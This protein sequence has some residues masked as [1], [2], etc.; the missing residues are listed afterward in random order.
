MGA[1]EAARPP[2]S[3]SYHS[4]VPS[5]VGPWPCPGEVAVA[6]GGSPVQTHEGTAAWA[7]GLADDLEKQQGTSEGESRSLPAPPGRTHRGP[8][9]GPA[10]CRPWLAGFP[11][12]VTNICSSWKTQQID[13]SPKKARLLWGLAPTNGWIAFWAHLLWN[14]AWFW[15]FK[16]RSSIS[17]AASRQ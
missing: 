12:P 14:Q 5:P 8:A 3:C 1:A 6:A 13:I 17:L 11:P 10:Q 2:A 9:V 15:I 4:R 16:S 7:G